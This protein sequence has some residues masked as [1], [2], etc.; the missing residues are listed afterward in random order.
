MQTLA[1]AGNPNCGKTTLFN[2]LTG[3]HQHVGNWAGV[4]VERREGIV[5]GS[6]A[7]LVDLPGLYSLAAF[8]LE[9]QVTREFL[10]DGSYDAVI[11]LLDGTSLERGLYLTLQL[12]ELGCP[13]AV[14][15]GMMDEVRALGGAI[16]C[17]VL[18]HILGVPVVPVAARSGEGVG[19]L[20]EAARAGARAGPPPAHG[21]AA[22]DAVPAVPRGVSREYRPAE[23]LRFYAVGLLEN[24]KL[25]DSLG[26]TKIQRRHI[27][28]IRSEF[29]QRCGVDAAAFLA[30]ARYDA[31]D[32]IVRQAAGHAAK[33]PHTWSDR[34]DTLALNR[35]LAFPIFAAVVS[36]IFT[37]CFGGMGLAMK[38]AAEQFFVQAADFL[39]R[40][41]PEL[42]VSSFWIGLAADGVVGGVGSVLAFLPQVALI[43]LCL[44]IL[45]ECGYLARAAFL[46]DYF[47]RRIGLT[48]KSFIP[49]LMG[50][51]C[52]TSAVMA[53]R[54]LGSDR[55]RRMT[56]LLTPYL[57]CSARLPI[58]VLL[59]GVFFPSHQGAAV[60]MLYLL[61][62][63]AACAVGF[64]LRT[65]PY[66]TYSAPYLMELPPY[67]VPSLRNVLHS[68]FSKCGDFLR[69]AGTLIFLLSVLIW[70]MQHINLHLLWTADASQ[71][72][73]TAVGNALAPLF[74]PLGFGNGKAAV[75]LLAGLV[76]KEAVV[77]S[78][79]VACAGAHS[80]ETALTELFTPLSAASFLTF[81]A[82][83]APCV[84]ALATMRRELHSIKTTV[85]AAVS[86][87]LVAYGAALAVYQIGLL[88]QRV[89]SS[90]P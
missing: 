23:Q 36:M 47:L 88:C 81:C 58:Y 37:I 42:G 61:G 65:G 63:A 7:R 87:I 33:R 82:L 5:R 38:R 64:W 74:R 84:S 79:G 6:S 53:A 83:Y 51:G 20:A 40:A 39:R 43:F 28:R 30:Q 18:A 10:L 21:P 32:A 56:I 77:S 48:G 26:L 19:L 72:I 1:L 35:F 16:D 59:T 73:F 3:A 69:K 86:Q 15:I 67:R 14:G 49:L 75:A 25:A 50:F 68:T 2:K 12:C 71:S 29:E 46:M 24:M 52:T 31:V 78:L 22:G 13:M 85:I 8:T 80:F 4:T 62:I 66:R 11:N 70:M 76:S 9:E 55:D 60:A 27:D 34:F 57:S 89:L 44:T 54:T 45:E 90:F 17:D 41:L